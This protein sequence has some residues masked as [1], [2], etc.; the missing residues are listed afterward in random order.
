MKTDTQHTYQTY[1]IFKENI[2]QTSSNVR[3]KAIKTMAMSS[4]PNA[5][6]VYE[7][8]SPQQEQKDNNW[9]TI[10]ESKQS[11]YQFMELS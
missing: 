5:T 4:P 8:L 6:I 2:Y 10:R 11:F 9:R 3:D 1:R 7:N